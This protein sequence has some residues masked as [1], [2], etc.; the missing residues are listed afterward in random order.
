MQPI[1]IA[2][3]VVLVAAF[4]FLL[5]RPQQQQQKK[6]QQMLAALKPGAEIVT[7]GGIYGTVVSTQGER[8]RLRLVDGAELEVAPRAVAT[9]VSEPL[10]DVEDSE[11]ESKEPAE[12]SSAGES[13][14]G[15]PA[16]D[17]DADAVAEEGGAEVGAAKAKGDS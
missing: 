14:D 9:V 2:F 3:L 6:Q 5:I 10:A 16:S 17:A 11:E 15:E 7:L 8:V 12:I 13:D 1:N 4:W